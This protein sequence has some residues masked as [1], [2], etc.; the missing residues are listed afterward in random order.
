VLLG[1]RPAR[2]PALIDIL[3]PNLVSLELTDDEFSWYQEFFW[4]EEEILVTFRTLFAHEDW[5]KM[6]PNIQRIGIDYE[7]W[8]EDSALNQMCGENGLNL[9]FNHSW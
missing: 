7:D 1:W 4:S 8:D 6:L 3:P 5:R 9:V 2:P